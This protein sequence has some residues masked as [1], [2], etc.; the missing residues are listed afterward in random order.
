MKCL[1]GDY[2]STNHT[3]SEY[4][5]VEALEE[6]SCELVSK[7]YSQE[8]ESDK[9]IMIKSETSKEDQS[10]LKIDY[11]NRIKIKIMHQLKA[12]QVNSQKSQKKF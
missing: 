9:R 7:S 5:L 8:N 3:C 2:N 4:H 11:L 6:N 10:T 12:N 1:S